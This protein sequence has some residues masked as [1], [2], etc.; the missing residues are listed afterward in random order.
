MT[1]IAR[2]IGLNRLTIVNY[3][4][5]LDDLLL[6]KRISVFSRK[7]K[8]K[9]ITHEK[10]YFFDTGVYRTIRPSGILDTKAEAEGVALETL[11]LQTVRALN[12]YYNLEYSINFWRTSEGHEVDFILYG[13]HGFHAFE[14]KRTKVITPAML[15][16]LKQFS[17]DYPES[18]LHLLFLGKNIEYYDKITATPFEEMLKNLKDVL[19][20]TK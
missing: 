15:K 18:T 3:F 7:A 8:R 19:F 5:I 1:E 6:S 14:I 20:Q 4:D 2:E 17:S 13:P 11:F 9:M 16:G 12:D 10:F